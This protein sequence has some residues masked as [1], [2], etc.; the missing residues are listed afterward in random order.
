MNK[1]LTVATQSRLEREVVSIINKHAENYGG[2]AEGYIEDLLTC[3]CQSGMVS[4]LLYCQDTIKFYA[5]H[6]R[7]ISY[8][9]SKALE[10]TGCSV[11]KLFGDKWDK[12]DPLALDQVNQN[13]LAWFAFV[14]TTCILADRTGIEL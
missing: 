3:G 4:E 13:L 11:D 8:L 6:K 5:Q 7:D 2:G 10:E 1:K 9:L 12:T 14:E